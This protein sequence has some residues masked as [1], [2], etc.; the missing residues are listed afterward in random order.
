MT[1]GAAASPVAS[2][3]AACTK[4]TNIE[5]I[6]DD[7]GSMS[8]T[9]S[10]KFRASLLEI[11]AGQQG[12]TGKKMGAVEFGDFGSV[13]FAPLAIGNAAAQASVTAAL[14][15]TINA[16]GSTVPGDFA[17]TNYDAGFDAA[18]S[19]NPTTDARIF[20][21]DGEPNTYTRATHL[22][23]ATKTYVVG[24]GGVG[25]SSAPLNEIVSDT[26]GHLFALTNSSQV[27]PVAGALTAVL[28]CKKPPITKT[29]VLSQ[30]E[31]K[32]Y[33]FKATGK[34]A[35]ILVTWPTTTATI[36]PS[37]GAGGGKTASVA[38]VQFKVQKGPTFSSVHLKGIKKGQKIKF[39]IKAKKAAGPTTVTTQIIR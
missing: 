25:S 37:L 15:P 12:N 39:K 23:P 32:G 33:S 11:L 28:N 29:A 36:V 1:S 9:D 6:I 34:T 22:N 8:G 4:A 20:L 17:G 35:D 18:K 13:L 30:G 21:S 7:S 10:G 5:A 14:A 31:L 38:K 26:G 3:S 2:A 16:D 19:A 24:F 27:Q